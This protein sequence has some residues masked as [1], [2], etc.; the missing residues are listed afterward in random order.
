LD[1]Q[2]RAGA[3]RQ[4][5]AVAHVLLDEQ[6]CEPLRH[7][8]GRARFTGRV[9]DGERVAAHRIVHLDSRA[10]PHD[11]RV[12][13]AGAALIGIQIEIFDDPLEPAAAENLLLQRLEAIL[14]AIGDGRSDIALR[15]ALRDDQDRGLR[16]V[17]V[18]Q[19]THDDD[20]RNRHKDERNQDEP[21][22]A[23]RDP[24]NIFGR[25]FASW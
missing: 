1:L 12:H 5:F 13:L 6:R 3:V 9:T 16:A 8:L 17:L 19:P 11:K 22:A 21:F 20:R 25:E 24:Q 10:H 4:L 14:D 7:D 15:H 2:E 23:Q 18:G